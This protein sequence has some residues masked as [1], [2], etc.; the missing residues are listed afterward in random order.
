MTRQHF[1][2]VFSTVN[3]ALQTAIVQN[4]KPMWTTLIMMLV[5]PL[6]MNANQYQVH[7]LPSVRAKPT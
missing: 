2:Q 4:F 6:L 1:W 5:Q 7:N 3:S